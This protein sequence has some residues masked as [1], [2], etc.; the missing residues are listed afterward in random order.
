MC[1]KLEW[2]TGTEYA[3]E[4]VIKGS[5]RYYDLIEGYGAEEISE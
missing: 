4:W 3:E 2:F 1:V 5:K